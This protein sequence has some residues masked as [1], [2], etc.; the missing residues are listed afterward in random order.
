LSR[1]CRE[2]FATIINHELSLN[3]AIRLLCDHVLIEFLDLAGGYSMHTCVHAWAV[4]VLNA[5][6]EILMARLV[7][8]CVGSAVPTKNVPEYWAKEWWLLSHVRKCF[9]SVHDAI[10]LESQDNQTALDAVHNLGI[11]YADQGKMVEAETMYR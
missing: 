6:R 7:L 4:H 3:Q 11:L 8:V 10:D 2:W 1:L 9:D 5:E